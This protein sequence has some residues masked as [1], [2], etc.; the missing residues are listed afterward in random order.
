[1]HVKLII[2]WDEI[3]DRP[4]IAAPLMETDLLDIAE[5]IQRGEGAGSAGLANWHLEVDDE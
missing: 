1:M 2:E 4:R 3:P 5:A